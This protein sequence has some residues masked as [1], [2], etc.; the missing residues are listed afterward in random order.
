LEFHVSRTVAAPVDPVPVIFCRV[1]VAAVVFF[2][3]YYFEGVVL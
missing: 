2:Y 1:I 3:G